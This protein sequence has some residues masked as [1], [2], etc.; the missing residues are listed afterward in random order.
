MDLL[1]AA[2]GGRGATVRPASGDGRCVLTVANRVWI[3]RDSVGTAR[4]MHDYTGAL[5]TLG[6][7]PAPADPDPLPSGLLVQ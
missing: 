4:V 2:R 1:A 6:L 7:V 3:C 5:G